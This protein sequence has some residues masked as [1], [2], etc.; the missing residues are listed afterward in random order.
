MPCLRLKFLGRA[1]HINSVSAFFV[2]AFTVPL[3]ACG[4]ATSSTPPPPP[5]PPPLTF[6]LVSN[7]TAQTITATSTYSGQISPDPIASPSTFSMQSINVGGRADGPTV[8]FDAA[9]GT[10]TLRSGSDQVA[11]S[12][13]NRVATTDYTHAFHS[14]TGA[15]TDDVVLYGNALVPAPS[16]TA[17]VQLTYSSYGFWKHKDVA[18]NLTTQTYFLYGEPT[19]TSEMPKS[20]SASYQATATG[21]VMASGSSNPTLRTFNGTAVLTADFAANTV[22]TTLSLGS[23]GT[24]QGA[25]TISVNQFSG[26]FTAPYSLFSSGAFTG[27]FFGPAASEAGYTFKLLYF[28]PD[29][30][31]G[32]SVADSRIWYSGVV[33]GKKN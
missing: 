10:Y 23:D 29:P 15:A 31:A 28:N 33:V 19:G 7:H 17:P 3:A 21:V 18:A 22:A 32:A 9:S 8:T 30:Y 5:A 13:T 25:G 12:A 16:A 27:G 4:G 6:P 20:G 2:L 1:M 24:Y 26:S 14:A 11:L